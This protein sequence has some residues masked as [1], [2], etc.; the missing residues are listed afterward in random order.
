MGMTYL[1]HHIV[2]LVLKH[3]AVIRKPCPPHAQLSYLI[4]N[5]NI[6]L[7]H[8]IQCNAIALT[9]KII[10][11]KFNNDPDS[12]GGADVDHVLPPALAAT[13]Q[14]IRAFST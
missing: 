3:V 6:S 2:V 8:S 5:Y 9:S 12:L 4:V 10:F 1:S 13:G 7:M 11:V 14:S